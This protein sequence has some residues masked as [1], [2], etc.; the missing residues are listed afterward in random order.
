MN[1]NINSLTRNKNNNVKSVLSTVPVAATANANANAKANANNINSLTRNKNNNVK[2]VLSTVP[3]AATANANANAKANANNINSLTRN[4]NNNVKSVLSTVPVTRKLNSNE[5]DAAYNLAPPNVVM[6]TKKPSP[7]PFPPVSLA[8]A[9]SP[10]PVSSGITTLVKN[11]IVPLQYDM[12]K[13]ELVVKADKK[14]F[15]NG[16]LEARAPSLKL[17]SEQVMKLV[18]T[19]VS[20]PKKSRFGLFS[21]TGK[22]KARRNTRRIH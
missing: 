10:I 22:A 5:L 21:R 9:P 14:G 13:C 12:E 6:D 20:A 17:L 1:N 4:K 8:T 19:S 15:R 16:Y 2:S 7:G 18:A 11:P 3:V